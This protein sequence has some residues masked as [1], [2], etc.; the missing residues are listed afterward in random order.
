MAAC[1]AY[2]V[3]QIAAVRPRVIVALGQS[4]VRDMLG[5]GASLAR[6]RGRWRA[7]G[8]TPVLATYHP[9]A[10]LYNRSLFR[11]LVTDL[12]KALRRAEAT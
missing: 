9:A 5:P 2:L 6:L 4:A 8:P 12:R 10:I 3:G 1:R 7:F 11:R